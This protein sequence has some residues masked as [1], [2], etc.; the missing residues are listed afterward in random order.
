[1]QSVIGMR[2]PSKTQSRTQ[3]PPADRRLLAILLVISIALV[4]THSAARFVLN[5]MDYS[6][7]HGNWTTA[8]RYVRYWKHA[9]PSAL[10][11]ALTNAIW[12]HNRSRI[13]QI[14]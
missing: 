14:L 5:R 6:L 3:K 2:Q 7:R 11:G 13:Q 1:M 9:S 4:G 10:R 8:D 12:Q